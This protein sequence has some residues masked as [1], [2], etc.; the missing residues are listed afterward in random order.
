MFLPA[1]RIQHPWKGDGRKTLVEMEFDGL[2]ALLSVHRYPCGAWIAKS[3]M[4]ECRNSE[5]LS[6]DDVSR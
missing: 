1:T 6:S 4:V 3:D 2:S 5:A